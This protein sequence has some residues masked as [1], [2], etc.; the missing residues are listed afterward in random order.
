[1]VAKAKVVKKAAKAPAKKKALPKPEKKD[2]Y[3]CRVCGYRIIVDD[4]GCCAEEHVFVCCGENM[5]KS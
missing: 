2:A 1:M 4:V 5:T 3:E